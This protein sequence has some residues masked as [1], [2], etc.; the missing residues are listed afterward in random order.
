[1]PNIA[2]T[3]IRSIPKKFGGVKLKFETIEI[4]IKEDIATVSLNRPDVHNAMSETL[5]K[6]LTKCFRELNQDNK[7][8][9]II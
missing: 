6:E 4:R 7:I 8:R 1:M 3:E 9:I 2:Q 5:M